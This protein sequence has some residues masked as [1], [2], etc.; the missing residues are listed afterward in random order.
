M[1]RKHLVQNDRTKLH[2]KELMRADTSKQTP[3]QSRFYKYIIYT[4]RLIAAAI[5]IHDIKYRIIDH[6]GE[7]AHEIQIGITLIHRIA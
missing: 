1:Y 2:V 4:Y 5:Q 7:D 6:T 3:G